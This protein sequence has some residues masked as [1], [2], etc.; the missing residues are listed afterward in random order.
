[1]LSQLL[2]A[3]FCCGIP[4]LLTMVKNFLERQG[5]SLGDNHADLCKLCC[6]R[7]ALGQKSKAKHAQLD[8]LADSV[9][10]RDPWQWA[11]EAF[12]IVFM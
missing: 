3:L 6:L 4:G 5:K 7:D 2:R 11:R 10:D 9:V 12:C 8:Q 1:M